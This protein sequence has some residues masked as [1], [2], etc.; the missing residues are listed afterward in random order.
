M[1]GAAMMNKRS[2][3]HRVAGLIALLLYCSSVSCAQG[4][5]RMDCFPDK[6]MYSPGDE[7]SFCL[8]GMPQSVESLRITLY[9]LD[10]AVLSFDAAA[11][12]ASYSLILPEIDFTG[13]LLEIQIQDAHKRIIG[14]IYTGID[15]SSEWT[16]YPRYGYVWDF[17]SEADAFSK[18]EQMTRYHL[19]GIQF[20]DW[21]Y[22]HHIPVAPDINGWQDWSGRKVNGTVLRSYIGE[23]HRR[24]MVCMA[25][26]MVY[27]AN[28][29]Y[30][31]DGS[32]VDPAW[33]LVKPNG[34]DFTC[35]MNANLGSVGILQYFNLLD[36]GW[37][38]YIFAQE[39]LVFDTFD[40]D[41]WHGD[42]IGEN[43][44]MQTADGGPL[45]HDLN[46]NPISLVKDGYLPFLNA[47]KIAIGDKYLVFNPVGAQGMEYVNV[48]QTDV[49]YTEF[50]PW[51][52]DADGM[53][54]D[55][56]YSIYKAILT[57][58]E[59]SG[60][61]S[62]IVAA[63]VNYRNPGVTFHAP[64]VRLMDS[65]VFASGGARIEIGNGGGMLSDEY[66]P[67]DRR[68]Q[69]DEILA[70]DMRR[71]YDFIVAYENL[72]RDGQS[73]IDRKVIIEHQHVSS[74]GQANSIWS[75]SK[76]DEERE[77]YHFINLLGTD[78]GW[79]DEGQTKN[80]PAPQID[81]VTRL[82]TDY[83]TEKVFL[84]TP[85]H[86]YIAPVTLEF[87]CGEDTDG[88]YIEFTV[89]SLSYWNMV[90]LCKST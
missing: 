88:R 59:Q 70:L 30:L 27:A 24:N 54:Y 79:R 57:A 35:N 49:L 1:N 16:R 43:G 81:L 68:K 62:L 29:T 58:H 19:N 32:G 14:A 85:D 65:V 42:T 22:R 10:K 4:E 64:A 73:P 74:N 21:Q 12:N 34:Q 63:Y 13:Y 41:G 46:G 86:E 44:R 36:P 55:S 7:V 66:F 11:G 5:D 90:F 25:Y 31:R 51:D 45:G 33:R 60:G 56:Y 23:A 83:P 80:T 17:T 87:I 48:S 75:F 78:S 38:S 82:Y 20:Y 26:N 37:Q 8:T 6:A 2:A 18:I 84:A 3:K 15:C 77:I 71:M 28:K 52:H 53:A 40:F 61:K 89:P 50:W 39:N 67:S 76:A 69:M 47:A 9:H 72:L